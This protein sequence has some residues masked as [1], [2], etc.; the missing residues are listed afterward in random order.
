M[1][2]LNVTLWNIVTNTSHFKPQLVLFMLI[3]TLQLQYI[4]IDWL[5]YFINCHMF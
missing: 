5:H 1:H 3:V 4:T 2:Y